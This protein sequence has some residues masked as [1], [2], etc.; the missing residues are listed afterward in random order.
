M[1]KN[2]LRPHLERLSAR[3]S[4]E[5]ITKQLHWG[6]AILCDGLLYA[7]R[8][9]N[10]ANLR[11]TAEKW[12]ASKLGAGPNTQ[13]WFW[14]WAAEALPALDL[15]EQTKNAAYLDYARKIV[16]FM[17]SS[18]T[19]TPGGAIV[20]HPPAMEVW[21]DVAYFTAPAMAQLARID[22]DAA[23]MERAIA[24]LIA[25]ARALLDP[26]TGL[27]W[28]VA[29]VDKGTH[30][31][32]LWA[33]GNSWWSIAAPQVLAEVDKAGMARKFAT[34][35]EE[36]I[37]TLARQLNAIAKLQDKGGLW[38]TV[39]DRPD[40][41]IEASSAAGFALGMIRALK[42]RLPG[43]DIDRI[44]ESAARAMAICDHIDKDGAFAGVSEQT[45]PGDFEFYNMV[46][47]G[48][49]PY[50]TGVCLMALSESFSNWE[51][52]GNSAR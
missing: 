9:L 24:Q 15:Y 41:Y 33:R 10:R 40:S 25:H 45:P 7:A 34:Q 16:E 12:F 5:L 13:G 4:S 23:R 2:D 43:L 31:P 3:A 42:M 20:P 48:T 8:T 19:H 36:V 1:N 29:Y 21:I 44:V 17:E 37:S 27:F 6:D 39:I 26:A 46:K 52:V 32:C 38:H 35:I 51:Q 50:A 47:I 11:E 18:A 28:H 14:V 49:A 30:S 22:G